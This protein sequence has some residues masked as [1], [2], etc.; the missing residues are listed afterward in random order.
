MYLIVQIVPNDYQ[1]TCPTDDVIVLF[2]VTFVI[3]NWNCSHRQIVYSV[4]RCVVVVTGLRIRWV[5]VN[6]LPLSRRAF[7]RMAVTGVAVRGWMAV[8]AAAEQPRPQP[9]LS[10]WTYRSAKL[11]WMAQGNSPGHSLGR[12]TTRLVH[13]N[14]YLDTQNVIFPR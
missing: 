1:S 4:S 3:L 10:Q 13:H 11:C 12:N 2:C 7:K 8:F 5:R 6:K 14:P 9:L